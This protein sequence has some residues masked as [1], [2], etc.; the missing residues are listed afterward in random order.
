MEIDPS[1]LPYMEVQIQL[2]ILEHIAEKGPLSQG[3]LALQHHLE[4]H[5]TELVQAKLSAKF[6]AA[7]RSKDVADNNEAWKRAAE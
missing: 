3:D 5:D 6:D 2:Q 4:A 1:K 7:P